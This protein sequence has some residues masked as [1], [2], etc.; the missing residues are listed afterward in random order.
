MNNT[1][2]KKLKDLLL[3]I[4]N[5]EERQEIEKLDSLKI[6]EIVDAFQDIE[7]DHEDKYDKLEQTLGTIV[8][9]FE[10]Y[11]KATIKHSEKVSSQYVGLAES[12][13]KNLEKLGGTITTS[14]EQNKPANAA[15]VYKDMINQIAAV[16]QSI[17]DKPVPVW[18][19]PQYASVSVRNKNFSN[20]NPSVDPFDVGSY[21][22]VQ[23]T[24]NGDNNITTATFFANNAVTAELT[25]TYSGTNLIEVER[26]Q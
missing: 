14:Y 22:D 16:N 26:T 23:L 7:K 19:W 15:G 13:T 12:L 18:N 3:S 9:S 21:D 1:K 25:L 11:R 24:Y 20:I 5:D 4:S 17:K 8:Q 10:N 2:K 6:K